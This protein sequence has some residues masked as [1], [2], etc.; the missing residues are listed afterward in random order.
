MDSQNS[1]ESFNMKN[2]LVFLLFLTIVSN[3]NFVEET[4]LLFKMGGWKDSMLRSWTNKAN[5]CDGSVSH[6][7]S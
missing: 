7:Y 5:M 2:K 1:K 3:Q 4:T 6:W